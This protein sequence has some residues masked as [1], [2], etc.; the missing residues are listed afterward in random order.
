MSQVFL[1]SRFRRKGG[2]SV[3]MRLSSA[4]AV[5]QKVDVL[6]VKCSPKAN[7]PFGK[8]TEGWSESNRH[9]TF[10]LLIQYFL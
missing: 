5:F 8:G 2:F 7:K 4:E 1:N 3:V 10:Q 6:L 9:F